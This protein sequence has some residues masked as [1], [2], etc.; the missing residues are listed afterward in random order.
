MSARDRVVWGFVGL[1]LTCAVAGCGGKEEPV[2]A[3][4]PPA[5]RPATDAAG[6]A[7]AADPTAR[8]MANAVTTNNAG[9]EVDLQYEIA[10][11]PEV[12]RP[13]EID[14]SFVPRLAADSLDAQLS[15]TSGLR[16][17]SAERVHFEAVQAEE[18]YT[19]KVIVIGDAPGLYY[20]GVV[21]RMATQVQTDARTFSIPVVIGT[22]P[23][24]APQPGSAPATA[25]DA[26]EPVPTAES[27]N[28]GT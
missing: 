15:A 13:F 22:E 20:I 21:A 16:I 6:Q 5:T 11:R 12:G 1:L 7:P 9:A 23:D 19:S 18:P 10:P 14:L 26:T 25:G 8:R 27:S 3:P 17:T 4:T 2:A 24:A 28:A